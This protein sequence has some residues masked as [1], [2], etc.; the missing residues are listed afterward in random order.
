MICMA[1]GGQKKELLNSLLGIMSRSGE[2]QGSLFLPLLCI[3]C[4]FSDVIQ[5]KSLAQNIQYG[6]QSMGSD[7]FVIFKPLYLRPADTVLSI[8]AIL[9]DAVFLQ[10]LKKFVE[11]NHNVRYFLSI[12]A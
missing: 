6:I 11:F 5:G 3:R 1:E 10:G 2:K 7:G 9:A 4:K 8:K 12:Y